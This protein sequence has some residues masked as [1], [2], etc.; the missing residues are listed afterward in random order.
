VCIVTR[1]PV[2]GPVP[3]LPQVEVRRINWNSADELRTL[4]E[5]F[6]IVAHLA[7]VNAPDS[8]ADPVMAYEFNVVSTARLVQAAIQA[9]VRRML[10]LST[11]H[12]YGSPLQGEISERLCPIPVHPYAISHRA[13]EDIVRAAHVA[14]KM[15]CIAVRVSNAFGAPTHAAVNCWMLVVNDLCRQAVV[16][17]QLLLNSS[18]K[19]FRDFVPM[20]VT[21]A[22]MAHLLEVP[23]TA[24]GDG[25]FNLGGNWS[26][27]VL[28]VAERIA[29][30]AENVLGC[31][32]ELHRR[33][34]E[35]GPEVKPLYYDTTRLHLSGFSM[36]SQAY[37]DTEILQLLEFCKL[38][39]SD[40]QRNK[41]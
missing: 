21:C 12:V 41:V 5:G 10:Y 11:A 16:D 34:N 28:D 2:A 7:G 32:L 30:L 8:A 35:I 20:Q 17:R 37:I 4:C 1:S 18:G 26:V 36:D 39:H 22:A 13:A 14:G 27:S 3:W 25:L 6:D 15:E 19:Q 9:G 23:V 29:A 31:K 38:N 33:S 24:L 40:L